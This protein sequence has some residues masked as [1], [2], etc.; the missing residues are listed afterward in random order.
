[1]NHPKKNSVRIE[2]VHHIVQSDDN[3]DDGCDSISYNVYIGQVQCQDCQEQGGR[4]AESRCRVPR[5]EMHQAPVHFSMVGERTVESEQGKHNH[6][7]I[8]PLERLELIAV[9]GTKRL[10]DPDVC[11]KQAPSP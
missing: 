4:Q 6:P 7:N 9:F 8:F 11:H 1:M 5:E 3:A 10:S 2:E